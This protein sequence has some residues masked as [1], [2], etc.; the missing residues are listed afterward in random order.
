MADVYAR[1][2]IRVYNAAGTT[3]LGTLTR[4]RGVRF[5][6][7]LHL[8]C[9]TISVQVHTSDP[10]LVAAPT[11]LDPLNVIKVAI[12]YGAGFVERSTPYRIEAD[13]EVLVSEGEVGDRWRTVTGRDARSFLDDAVIYPESALGRYTGDERWFGFMSAQGDWYVPA[14][15]SAPSFAT[16]NF[17]PPEGFPRSHPAA[18]PDEPS[19]RMWS[20]DPD[21][22]GADGVYREVLFRASFTVPTAG[23]YKI[24]VTADDFYE[25]YLDG[26]LSSV[27]DARLFQWLET[28][29]V[30]RSFVPGTYRLALKGWD[31]YLTRSFVMVAVCKVDLEGKP[32]ETVFRSE[33]GAGWLQHQVAPNGT[34]VGWRGDQI[35]RA[36]VLEAQ[37]RGATPVDSLTLGFTNTL[38]SAGVAWAGGF[39]D[40]KF[41]VGTSVLDALDKLTELGMDVAV[42]PGMVLNAWKQRGTNKTATVQ[43]LPGVNLVEHS[44]SSQRPAKTRLLLR[45]LDKWSEVANSTAETALGRIEGFLSLGDTTSQGHAGIVADASLAELAAAKVVVTSRVAL[46]TGALPYVDFDLGDLVRTTGR[47]GAALDVTVLAH[48]WSEGDNGLLS[49][50]PEWVV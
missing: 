11:L 43:F 38:D 25:L 23:N 13:D 30:A 33:A 5:S 48:N 29:E 24:Y 9:G 19:K 34:P 17:R 26:Q 4:R 22:T 50:V 15:W 10:A 35:L 31:D 28:F 6:D 49:Y 39:Q 1:A 21:A 2:E 42:T 27:Q 47:G 3:L 18:W 12:D 32:T 7:T 37:A 46:I 40:R 44:L 41:N 8:P 14:D 20:V 16:P 45:T 36:L